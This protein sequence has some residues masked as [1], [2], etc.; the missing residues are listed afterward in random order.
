MCIISQQQEEVV[1]AAVSEYLEFY[2]IVIL[3]IL[4]VCK[5]SF[6]C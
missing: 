4:K 1:I 5:Y 6:W 3:V 2:R